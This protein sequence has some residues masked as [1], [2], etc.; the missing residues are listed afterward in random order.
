MLLPA[1]RADSNHRREVPKSGF[2]PTVCCRRVLFAI[3]PCP[4]LLQLPLPYKATHSPN[5]TY[6]CVPHQNRPASTAEAFV[7]LNQ[8]S[9][10]RVWPCVDLLFIFLLENDS[11]GLSK[12]KNFS[13]APPPTPR[14]RTHL[15]THLPVTLGPLSGP[16]AG[17]GRAGLEFCDARVR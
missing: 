7:Q 16:R 14:S 9:S 2:E 8:A 15:W 1:A 17:S 11:S 10:R 12:A 4:E 13:G 3:L 6:A 5:C